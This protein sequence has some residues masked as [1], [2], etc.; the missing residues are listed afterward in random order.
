MGEIQNDIVY[1]LLFADYEIY[2]ELY[3]FY[4][5]L[6]KLVNTSP[7]CKVIFLFITT[8]KFNSF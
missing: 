6:V 7:M 3:I 4:L 5:T 1:S 8:N 2:N